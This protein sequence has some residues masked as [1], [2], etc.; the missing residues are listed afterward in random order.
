MSSC[1]DFEVSIPSWFDYNLVWVGRVSA[2]A[3]VSIPSWFD[4]NSLSGS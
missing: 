2:T 1:G 4:Y 3:S